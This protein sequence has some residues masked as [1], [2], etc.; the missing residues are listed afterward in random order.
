MRRDRFGRAPARLLRPGERRRPTRYTIPQ[1]RTL[2]LLHQHGHA[3]RV[4][5]GKGG[6]MWGWKI[7]GVS[8]SLTVDAVI[9]LGLAHVVNDRAVLTESGEAVVRLQHASQR[10]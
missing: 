8:R 10:H 4:S 1:V 2:V 7:G 9:R 6:G 3:D 5:F